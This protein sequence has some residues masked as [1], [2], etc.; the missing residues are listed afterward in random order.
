[1]TSGTCGKD[2]TWTLDGN[3][4]TISG[5][6]AMNNYDDHYRYGG[7]CS[8]WYYHNESIKR[9][10]IEDGVTSI[11]SNAF[12]H[13]ERLE[14]V[15]IPDSVTIIANNAFYYCPSLKEMVIP[16][17]VT[18][19]GRDAFYFC[20]SLTWI[21]LPESIIKIGDSAFGSCSSLT[22]V[23]IPE[24]VTELGER[25]FNG[26]KDIFFSWR[27]L[28]KIYYRANSGFEGKL[29]FNNDAE[30]IPVTPKIPIWKVE[31]ATLTVDGTD[32]IRDYSGETPPWNDYIRIIQRIVIGDGVQKISAHAFSDCSRLEELVIPASIKTIGDLA[33]TISYCG[34]RTINNGKNVFWSLD[35][36]TL[37]IKKNPDVNSDAD[38]STGYESWKAAEKNIKQIRI[39]RGIFP[40][41]RFFEW[42]WK[43]GRDAQIKLI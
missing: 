3:T 22:E 7:T 2:L 18:E 13:H 19:I 14:E 26:C 40:S 25:I 17:G 1:M 27:G 6:G 31:G 4:L 16:Y 30:L 11:G 41:K 39:E 8:P 15:K 29:S 38:F 32:T 10:I 36:G 35:N 43:S 20:S 21:N 42:L 28:K 5:E 9:V 12:E 24:S 34:E 23:T 33:F 37:L